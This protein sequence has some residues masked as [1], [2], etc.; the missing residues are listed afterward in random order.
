MGFKSWLSS[1]SSSTSPTTAQHPV[2]TRSPFGPGSSRVDYAYS[3]NQPSSPTAPGLA[4]SY[5]DGSYDL[6]PPYYPESAS[7]FNE[8][9]A[10]VTMPTPYIGNGGKTHNPTEL[11]GESPLK[12]LE[13]H[14]IAIVLDDSYS[15]LIADSRSGRTRWDQVGDVSM[16]I[17]HTSLMSVPVTGVE[18]AC[19]SRTRGVEIRQRRNR[20]P[21]PEQTRGR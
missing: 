2:G 6:P 14:D 8:W 7:G 10:A 16:P 17:R 1:K 19:N 12:L 21:F 13:N 4:H 9:P 5:Y 15:M 20:D 11:A 3:V 18:R